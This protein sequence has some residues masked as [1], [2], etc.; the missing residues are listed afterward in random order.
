MITD[1][2]GCE[3]DVGMSGRWPQAVCELWSWLLLGLL[4]QSEF[5]QPND[6]KLQM[7]SLGNCCPT[8][9]A[10]PYS[11]ALTLC[12]VIS[13]CFPVCGLTCMCAF[14]WCDNIFSCMCACGGQRSMLGV[15]LPV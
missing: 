7:D 10:T 2:D 11:V 5:L 9:I 1:W 13:K 14:V 3:Q 8:A 6:M 4:L 12:A 15:C